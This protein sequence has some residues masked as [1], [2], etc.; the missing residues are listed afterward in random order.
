M[1]CRERIQRH[2]GQQLPGDGSGSRRGAIE[3]VDPTDGWY[4]GGCVCEPFAVLL[5]GRMGRSGGGSLR[6]YES[7]HFG[8]GAFVSLALLKL[9]N[10][11]PH[12][13]PEGG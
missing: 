1:S 3:K 4:G 7:H 5:T 6:N 13:I 2:N 11:G 8:L 12:V 9:I 10:S